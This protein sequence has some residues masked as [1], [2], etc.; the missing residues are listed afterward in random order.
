MPTICS[1]QI[2]LND[3]AIKLGMSN[4]KLNLISAGTLI[5]FITLSCS[6]IL[7]AT[8]SSQ[9]Y[10]RAG[11]LHNDLPDLFVFWEEMV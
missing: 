1:C 3:L 4:C 7:K 6:F 5:K 2:L 11:C 9:L 8:L 10:F